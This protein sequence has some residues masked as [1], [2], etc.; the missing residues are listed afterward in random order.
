MAKYVENFVCVLGNQ[1]LCFESSLT[2]SDWASWVQAIGSIFA[3]LVAILVVRVQNKQQVK[4]MNDQHGKQFELLAIEYG[5]Q[6]ELLETQRRND[7]KRRRDQEVELEMLECTRALLVLE[8]AHEE[9][10]LLSQA[11]VNARV[12]CGDR[13]PF[14]L[15]TVVNFPGG[16]IDPNALAFLMARGEQHLLNNLITAGYDADKQIRQRNFHADRKIAIDNLLNE[17]L[18]NQVDPS[19]KDMI[20]AIGERRFADIMNYLGRLE[21]ET[22]LQI[23]MLKKF[24]PQMVESLVRIYPELVVPKLRAMPQA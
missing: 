15:Q 10:D 18:Q 21:Y 6:L 9:A 19:R 1:H 13:W 2:V 22:H 5:K 23:E 11:F 8:R 12:S 4:L 20:D 7:E 16:G 24:M 14:I 17:R 3:I